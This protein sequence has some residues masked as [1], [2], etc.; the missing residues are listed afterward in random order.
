MGRQRMACSCYNQQGAPAVRMTK[1]VHGRIADVRAH[2]PML[3][4]SEDAREKHFVSSNPGPSPS[5]LAQRVRV[6]NRAGLRPMIGSLIVGRLARGSERGVRGPRGGPR[7]RMAAGHLSTLRPPPLRP[8]VGTKPIS[9]PLHVWNARTRLTG[10]APA[11][12]P[13]APPGAP[14]SHPP[15]HPPPP[16]PPPPAP[17]APPPVPRPPRP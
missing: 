4:A 15:C 12:R 11:P 13:A 17:A 6:S 5:G 14:P 2:T 3:G 10:D 16:T 1:Q 9:R 7:R 8:G